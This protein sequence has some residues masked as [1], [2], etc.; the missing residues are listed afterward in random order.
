MSARKSTAPLALA[1]VVGALLLLVAA[2]SL[3]VTRGL[4]TPAAGSDE[5]HPAPP[6][7]LVWSL[8]LPDTQGAHQP[9]AQWRGKVLVVNFWATWCPPCREEMPGFSR[10]QT[11]YG[12]R[13]VQVVGWSIDTLNNVIQFQ[14]DAPV[15]YPLLIGTMDLVDRSVAWGNS[16][17][18]MPF[19]AIFGRDG[20]LASVHLGRMSE[21]AL[22]RA[23]KA[24]LGP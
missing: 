1:V 16:A 5:P 2:A 19:T 8:T 18:A 12:P 7:T 11:K 13:G 22:E 6:A 10:V 21:D 24:L 17:Q 14:N 9:M 4:D 3:W 23:I 20:Q 15:V